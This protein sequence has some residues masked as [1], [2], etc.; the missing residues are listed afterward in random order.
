MSTTTTTEGK[1]AAEPTRS[2]ISVGSDLEDVLLGLERAQKAAYIVLENISDEYD[3][4]RMIDYIDALYLANDRIW[5]ERKRLES[6]MHE[7]YRIGREREKSPAPPPR[8][9][10]NNN[11]HTGEGASV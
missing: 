3:T 7:C 6:L 4:P 8:K 2:V 9:T 11:K 1:K 5:D 10:F